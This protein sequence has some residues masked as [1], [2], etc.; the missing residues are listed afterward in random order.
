VEAQDALAERLDVDALA[1]NPVGETLVR[2]SVQ[3][4]PALP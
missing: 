2:F 3:D 4:V 1:R